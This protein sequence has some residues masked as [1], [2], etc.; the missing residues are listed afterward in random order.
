[1][2]LADY[3]AAKRRR[4]LRAD[5]EVYAQGSSVRLTTSG[6]TKV[7]RGTLFSIAALQSGCGLTEEE[8]RQA[9]VTLAACRK[10][11]LAEQAAIVNLDNL[12][13]RVYVKVERRMRPR[14]WEERRA[15]MFEPA[16]KGRSPRPGSASSAIAIGS[17]LRSIMWL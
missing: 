12:W 16:A 4:D 13:E 2:P 10:E 3:I 9:A 7:G 11:L 15:G 17:E 14:Y 8:A 6:G 5:R 1:M